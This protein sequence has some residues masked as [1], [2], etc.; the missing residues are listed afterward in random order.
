[1]KPVSEGSTSAGEAVSVEWRGRAAVAWVPAT[2]RVRDLTMSDSAVRSAERAVAALRLADQLIPSAWETLA[3]LLMRHEGIASS[4]IEGLR[5][6]VTSVLIAERIGLG[7]AAGWVAD[8][9]AVIDAA[10]R[11]SSESLSVE[12]LHEWHSR[13]MRNSDLPPDMIGVFRASLGWIGGTSPLDAAYVPPP[14]A[15]IRELI[16]DL[17]Q[18]ADADDELDAVS[19]AAIVHAQ[20]VAIHPYGDGNGRLGRVLVSRIL[21]RAGATQRSVAPIS[22]SIERDPGG[23]LSGL[24]LFEAGN[25]EAWVKWFAQI[26]EHAAGLTG[27][28]VEQSQQIIERWHESAAALRRDS[29][30]R[31]LLRYLPG[32]PVINSTDV[33]ALL[34]VSQRTGRTAL[35]SLAELGVLKPIDVSSGQVGRAHRWFAATDLLQSWRI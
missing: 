14:P 31:A 2:L 35:E 32:H 17:V 33:A 5:E 23:Y 25:T 16:N 15:E 22:M 13:L 12:T 28:V 34:D 10:M 11:T 3:R 19:R 9:L 27:G 21:R 7:G 20:F 18:F 26:V 6:P 24:R 1:M 29:A 8:N 30:A 4:G